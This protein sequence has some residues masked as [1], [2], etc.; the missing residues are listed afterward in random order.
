[1]GG[2]DIDSSTFSRYF[3]N[4]NNLHDNLCSSL[5]DKSHPKGDQLLK[6]IICS[7][8]SKFFLVRVDPIGKGINT[9]TVA[10]PESV[11]Q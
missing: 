8:G 6:G 11:P 3:T 10:S 4:K 5:K 1:M 2:G 7:I 9:D